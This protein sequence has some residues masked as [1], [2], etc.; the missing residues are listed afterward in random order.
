M[1]GISGL[2]GFAPLSADGI[3]ASVDLN[4]SVG[5]GYVSGKYSPLTSL[6]TVSRTTTN[7]TATNLLPTSASGSPYLTFGNNVLRH[8]TKG[9]LVEEARVNQLLNST[10]P[11]TQTTASLGTGTYT[12]W[13]N[14][15]GTAT[16]SAGT[17]TGCGTGAATQG[18]PVN[19]TI[20]VAGTCTVTVS[21]SLNAFQLELGS[22]GTSLIVTG[23]STGSRAS[24]LISLGSLTIGS[25]FTLLGIGTPFAPTT[26]GATQVITQFDDGSSNNR[27]LLN[28]NT[29]NANVIGQSISGGTN[30]GISTGTVWAQNTLGKVALGNTN[31]AQALVFN[32]GAIFTGAGN[33]PVS[34]TT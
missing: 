23:G 11:A 8:D 3:V 5:Q 15:S 34:P 20:S 27:V 24:D 30:T 25:A 17:G 26:F 2:N 6:L 16:M 18:N 13:V 14:G 28:R 4:C 32:G 31:G 7:G 21:G 12:L 19:F 29:G 1:D 22:F 9:C 33:L 10:A